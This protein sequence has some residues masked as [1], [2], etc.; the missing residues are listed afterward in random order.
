MARIKI[1]RVYYRN[2]DQKDASIEVLYGETAVGCAYDT[3]NRRDHSG[4]RVVPRWRNLPIGQSRIRDWGTVRRPHHSGYGS[5]GSAMLRHGP[6]SPHKTFP[7]EH[8]G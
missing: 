1:G 4:W 2:T 8:C 3:R 5:G 7:P 6:N